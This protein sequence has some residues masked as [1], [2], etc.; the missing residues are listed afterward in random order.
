MPEGVNVTYEDTIELIGYGID[1]TELVC[2]WVVQGGTCDDRVK[3][4]DL[5]VHLENQ[6]GI[7]SNSERYPCLWLECEFG[8]NRMMRKYALERH[9]RE[10][11]TPLRWICPTCEVTFSRKSSLMDHRQRCPGQG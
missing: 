4:R 9:L 6:H 2:Q 5:K 7:I 3:V 8:R 10:Q 1:E 11:H